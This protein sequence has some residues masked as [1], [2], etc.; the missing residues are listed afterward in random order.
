M[1][2]GMQEKELR[3]AMICY[4]GVSLAVYMHGV[5]KEVWR[6]ARAS[7]DHADQSP[8]VR[9]G[10]EATYR[11]ILAAAEAELGLRLRIVPDIISGASAGG[12]NGVFLAQ[13]LESGQSLDPLTEMWLKAAD[14]DTLIDSDARPL[15]RFTKFWVA[16]LLWLL[17]RR[18]GDTVNRTVAPETREEVRRKLSNL[19]RAR[20][21]APPFGGKS[22]SNLILDA[23]DAM[24]SAENGAPLLPDGHPLD[25]FVTVTDFSGHEEALRLNS[26][27]EVIETE[28]RLTI[29]FSSRGV[30]PRS[31][32]DAAELAF[33]ARATASFPGA[34]PPFTVRE[35][36]AVLTDRGRE[37]PGREQFLA[38]ILPR[39]HATGNAE[40]AVLIDGSVLANAPF[41]QAI[42]AL[43][44]RPARRPVDRRIVY[45]EPTPSSAGFRLTS[46][47]PR[48]ADGERKLPGFFRTIFGAISDIPREQPIRD[49]LE[50]IAQRSRRIRRMQYIVNA[51]RPDIENTV[52]STVGRTMFLVKPTAKRLAH[53][54]A[55]LQTKAAKAAGFTYP[56]YGHLKL[57]SVVESLAA[58]VADVR[59]I[60][61]AARRDAE[62]VALWQALRAHGV[63]QIDSGLRD[64]ASA[65]LI[66]F[67]RSH[68]VDFR[69]RRLRFVARQMAPVSLAVDDQSPPSI[70]AR[71]AMRD[72]LYDA[73]GHYSE[74]QQAAWI[75]QQLSQKGLTLSAEPIEA[76]ETI[77]RLCDL[78]GLDHQVDERLAAAFLAL[79]T[80]ERKALLRAYLG[81]PFFDIATLPLLQGEGLDEYDPIKVDRISPDDA[82]SIRAGGA[83]ATL[84]GI[85]F[86][87]FGAFF[88]RA[89]RENDYLWGRLHGAERMIDILIST[90]P[91]GEV[92]SM[93]RVRRYKR[94]AF[95]AILDEEESQLHRVGGLIAS[96]RREI[97]EKMA[98][99]PQPSPAGASPG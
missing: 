71:S 85:E 5:T 91:S 28:H 32:G 74:R 41:A 72:A 29:G 68:D 64:G 52:E 80:D 63:E 7:R 21:F 58:L 38:R 73:I 4:G 88:S 93:D 70:I 87:S 35:L 61:G 65:A 16:P 56:A 43:K 8:S 9:P 26:P 47:G 48:D 6:L 39:H 45:I 89:Y 33:A 83:A 42:D 99:S 77:E 96:L 20:W 90:L 13:A 60:S 82:T 66:A 34:F 18:R 50:T 3:L 69:I 92:T 44:D 51:L 22:F 86:N 15:S 97:D 54:R 67:Y 53:W 25:L 14:A 2:G 27:A 1:L 23:F 31:L 11:A 24:A 84:R 30:R 98:F 46:P 78:R 37:W 76:I 36:D 12:I 55:R 95:I 59:E 10:S 62:R 19:V 17:L 81:F 94:A 57:S 49:N 79:P 75:K 40:D